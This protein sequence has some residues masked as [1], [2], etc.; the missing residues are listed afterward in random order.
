MGPTH[1]DAD[2]ELLVGVSVI[3]L[4]TREE[5]LRQPSAVIQ[6]PPSLAMAPRAPTYVNPEVTKVEQ[7]A[8]RLGRP[9]DPTVDKYLDVN[10]RRRANLAPLALFVLIAIVLIIYFAS[11]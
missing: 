5:L 2:D 8:G 7:A 6:I 11:R 4:R 9:R 10:V 3:K 1:P